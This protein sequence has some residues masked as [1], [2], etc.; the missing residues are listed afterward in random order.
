MLLGQYYSLKVYILFYH[1]VP[2]KSQLLRRNFRF[3]MTRNKCLIFRLL[4]FWI[5]H[6]LL[7]FFEFIFLLK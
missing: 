3:R 1:L 2:C 4:N 6:R 5:A 7:D